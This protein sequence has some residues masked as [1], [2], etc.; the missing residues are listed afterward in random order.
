MGNF[1][2]YVW[3]IFFGFRFLEFSYVF[4]VFCIG[5]PAC[6]SFLLVFNCFSL[7]VHPFP[8]SIFISFHW[9][10]LFSFGFLT[11]SSRFLRFSIVLWFDGSS[12]IA[13]VALLEKKR[14]II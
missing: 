5:F 13:V 6:S 3:G 7:F 2:F 1:F 4:L 14:S 9:F 10:S 11:F 12:A 8:F